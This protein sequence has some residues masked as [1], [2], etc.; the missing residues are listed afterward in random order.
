MSEQKSSSQSNYREALKD[1]ESLALFLAAMADFDGAFCDAMM[2]GVDFTLRLEIHGN[3]KEMLHAR[4]HND[5]FRRPAG[6][7]RP[8]GRVTERR[9]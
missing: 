2:S 1:D 6:V 8:S 9:K 4:V 7:D 3:N 5:S